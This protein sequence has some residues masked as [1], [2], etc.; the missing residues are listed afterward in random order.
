M[1]TWC[2]SI[3]VEHRSS[4]L[5][6]IYKL[7]IPLQASSQHHHYHAIVCDCLGEE[8]GDDIIHVYGNGDEANMVHKI[9][10]VS[11]S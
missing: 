10:E 6:L 8:E 11:C 5:K 3:S 2:I 9:R 1:M 4:H 7:I